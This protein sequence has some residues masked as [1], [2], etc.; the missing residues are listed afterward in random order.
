MLDVSGKVEDTFVISGSK[1]CIF[2]LLSTNTR[3]RKGSALIGTV[4]YWQACA[5]Q[6][7]QTSSCNFWTWHPASAGDYA[8]RCVL[9]AGYGSL[10]EDGNAVSGG[11]G[12]K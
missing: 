9:M 12:C 6:C 1:K 10:V 7:S 5:H 8:L 11:K 3:S 4:S 2:P